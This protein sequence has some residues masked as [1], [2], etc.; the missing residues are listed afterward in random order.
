M[1]CDEGAINILYKLEYSKWAQGKMQLNS[2]YLWVQG[3]EAISGVIAD[4]LAM[5]D[6]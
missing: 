5:R 1:R 4:L 6:F 3:L 2:S